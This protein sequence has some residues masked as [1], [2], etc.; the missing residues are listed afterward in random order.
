[1]GPIVPSPV[2]PGFVQSLKIIKFFS[3]S[4]AATTLDIGVYALL[5]HSLEPYLANMVSASLGML[6]NFLMQWFW[7]FRATRK[8]YVSFILSAI[9]SVGGIFLGSFLVYILTTSTPLER[10]PM[11]AKL[12]T[13]IFIFFYNY[14][15]KKFSFG[16]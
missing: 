13:V 8:W 4:L 10:V 5:I 3:T 15:T 12:V 1:M 2:F 11:V 14:L 9:F 6:A 16:D 7:V